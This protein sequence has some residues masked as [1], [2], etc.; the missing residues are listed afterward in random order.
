[1][2]SVGDLHP[3]FF[4]SIPGQ[5][6]SGAKHDE[7]DFE[8]YSSSVLVLNPSLNPVLVEEAKRL[9]LKAS[10][11]PALLMDPSLEKRR[12]AE[13]RRSWFHKAHSADST[14]HTESATDEDDSG[15]D[16]SHNWNQALSDEQPLPG[17]VQGYSRVQILG[18]VPTPSGKTSSQ[19]NTNV[20]QS[21]PATYTPPF[22]HHTSRSSAASSSSRREIT[23]KRSPH[24]SSLPAR[25]KLG[26]SEGSTVGA[27]H[28]H[29]PLPP[30]PPR[31]P[32]S[33][34]SGQGREGKGKAG[35]RGRGLENGR[36]QEGRRGMVG[37]GGRRKGGEDRVAGKEEGECQPCSGYANLP[38]SRSHGALCRERSSS[39]PMLS[40]KPKPLPRLTK[41]DTLER[42]N[43]KDKSFVSSL[44]PNFRPLPP[45][46]KPTLTYSPRSLRS[47]PAPARQQ[48]SQ[49]HAPST[50]DPGSNTTA[51]THTS[52][53]GGNVKPH[54]HSPQPV[55]PPRRKRKSK[56]HPS[57]Q[58]LSPIYSPPPDPVVGDPSRPSLDSSL[59]SPAAS[60]EL[61]SDTGSSDLDRTLGGHHEASPESDLSSTLGPAPPPPSSPAPHSSTTSP[62]PEWLQ[63]SVGDRNSSTLAH[64]CSVP[65]ERLSLPQSPFHD[66]HSTFGYVGEQEILPALHTPLWSSPKNRNSHALMPT[67]SKLVSPLHV[68]YYMH[69]VLF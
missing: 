35:S 29:K 43:S 65:S 62:S 19:E 60:D 11:D 5:S 38:L 4:R 50:P 21:A 31:K 59:S 14:L 13:T 46:R 24:S 10:V 57:R 48:G 66:D 52:K 33:H 6:G 64:R 17:P 54:P 1:M 49:P 25:G 53:R 67:S 3:F 9:D 41:A 55:P 23:T 39:N 28:R 27:S 32:H 18:A 16:R 58:N 36:G 69:L 44:P 37:R 22:L 68:P 42:L 40:K 45:P 56:E 30:T 63:R 2:F 7:V 26:S 51:N 61:P 34:L 15:D 12:Q 20:T 8:K 47:S